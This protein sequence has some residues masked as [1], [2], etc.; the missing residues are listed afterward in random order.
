MITKEKT[1]LKLKAF[2]YGKYTPTQKELLFS[3]PKRIRQKNFNI[4]E[5]IN[6]YS[7]TPRVS[8]ISNILDLVCEIHPND[9]LSEK[10][11]ASLTRQIT[12][13]GITGIVSHVAGKLLAGCE[14]SNVLAQ[15]QQG[16]LEVTDELA[17]VLLYFA[18]E[19]ENVC[20]K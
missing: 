7:V 6:L 12:V 18:R 13:C 14:L 1:V 4:S 20:S 2:V 5:L 16:K 17:E 10:E 19:I 3:I 9:F 15:I 11:T 8:Y